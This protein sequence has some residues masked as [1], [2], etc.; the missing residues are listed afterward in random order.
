MI[1]SN[2]QLPTDPKNMD[3]IKYNR[4]INKYKSCLTEKELGYLQTFEVKSS[5]F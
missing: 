5:N 2:E 3:R 4:F 1:N